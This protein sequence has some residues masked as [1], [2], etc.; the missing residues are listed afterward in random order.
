VDTAEFEE[1]RKIKLLG[2]KLFG[3]AGDCIATF[4]LNYP[5]EAKSFLKVKQNLHERFHG[6]DNRK[7]YFTEFKNCIRN[8]G[9]S[10][11]DYACRLQKLYLF[12]YPTEE[13]KPIDPAVLQLRET[14]LMD[15]FIGGLKSNLRE[16]MSFKDYKNLNDLVKATEKCAAVLSEAKLEKRSVEFVNAI[17]ADANAHELRE[18]KNE[19]SEL[20]S[21]IEQLAQKLANTTLVG[22]NKEAVNVVATTQATQI[23]ESKREIKE[24]KNLLRASNKNYSD[25]MKQSRDVEKAMKNLQIQ[26][27][28][29][30][31]PTSQAQPVMQYQ[32]NHSSQ[33]VDKSYQGAQQT[34]QYYNNNQS[35]QSNG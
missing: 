32:Q 18:T 16:R 4:Q 23:T 9:E 10:I 14:M 29:T 22:N 15:G 12:A 27:A 19:I 7:M 33:F 21:V 8:S 13:G 20:R 25:M 3:S 17:S 1:G 24:L 11:R 30:S 26:V 2:S 6:G 28:G 34:P 31:Q 35:K 5:R